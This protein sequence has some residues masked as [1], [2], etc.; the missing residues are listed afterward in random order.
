M[1]RFS[2]TARIAASLAGLMVSLLLVA[3]Y[4]GLMPDERFAV[5]DGRRRLCESM[6]IH[7]SSLAQRGDVATM[8]G[9]LRAFASR[10]SNIL[11]LAVRRASGKIIAETGDHAANW[12]RTSDGRSIP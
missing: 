9:S 1:Q 4:F 10:N 12:K 11:S 7:F 6:A 8:N 2:A 5:M 3:H